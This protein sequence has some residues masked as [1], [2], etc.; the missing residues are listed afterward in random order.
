MRNP[1]KF[2][3]IPSHQAGFTL[4]ELVIVLV[5]IG[6]IL[7]AVLKGQQMVENGKIKN[8]INDLQGISVAYHAYHD[9]YQAIPGD[10]AQAAAHF[11]GGIAGDGDGMIA[12]LFA[13]TDAPGIGAE[14]NNFWQ[15]L[16]LSGF[17]TGSGSNPANH[18]LNGVLGVQG[19][20]VT[21]GMTGNVVC[22]GSIPQ[23]I[24]QA[25][26]IQLDDGDSATGTLRAGVA[27]ASNQATVPATSTAYGA[28][29]PADTL[30][31]L[32]MKL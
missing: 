26:D 28:A 4:I 29:A 10:D 15:H 1:D 25:V 2:F 22:A 3:D 16:R 27:G 18:S 24:A 13:A 21:Y 12:G 32:C 23:K 20:V 17:L 11:T 9:R 5:I 8:I 30:H 7:G 6:L 31:T 14:S 19:A